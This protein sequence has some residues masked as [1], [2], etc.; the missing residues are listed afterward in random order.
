MASEV[1]VLRIDPGLIAKKGRLEP[2][3]MFLVDFENGRLIPD[4]ELKNEFANRNPYGDWLRGNRIELADLHP[5][6]EAHGFDPDTLL[7]RMQTFGY[8]TETMQFML[9]PLIQQLR[10]PVGSMG[11]DSALACLSDKPRMIY[12]YFKQL[13]AQVTNPAIDSIRE[14]NIM[15]LECY[16]GPELNLLETTAAHA[17]R[18]HLPHPILTNEELAAI[19]HMHVREWRTKWIDITFDRATEMVAAIDRICTEAEQA[20]EDGFST[21][22][23]SDRAVSAERIPI[24]AL[25]ACGM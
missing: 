3:R 21:I 19:G 17:N 1:G 4:D 9:L 14:E 16:V 25:L 12:D 10:D 24:S 15:S 2:G 22:I 13:F 11:N 23:L 20:I 6:S 8:T 7:A 18:L 5:S